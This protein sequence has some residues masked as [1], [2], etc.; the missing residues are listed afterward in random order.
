MFNQTKNHTQQ[1]GCGLFFRSYNVS[2]FAALCLF[3]SAVEYAIPKPLP[4]LRLGLANLPVLIAAKKFNVKEYA[5]LVILKILGQALLSGTLFS[6]V[7]VFSF[8]GSA[9]SA[10]IMYL[11]WILCKVNNSSGKNISNIGISLCGALGNNAAQIVCARLIMFGENTKYIAPLLLCSGFVTGFLLGIFSLFFEEKSVWLKEKVNENTDKNELVEKNCGNVE[12][13]DIC[14]KPCGNLYEK[15]GK[16]IIWFI[17]GFILMICFLF[18]QS[19]PII[20]GC[21][22]VFYI[23]A[24]IRRKG[25]VKLLPSLFITISVTIFALISP[26]GKVLFTVGKLRI[27]EGALLSGLHRSGIL[28]GM[29]FLSQIIV[30]KRVQLPGKAGTFVARIFE[31]LDALGEKRI[32]FAKGTVISSI[33]ARLCEIWEEKK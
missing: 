12:N 20:W 3:L 32:K 23:I 10:I 27:T 19:V 26:F 25:K 7:F 6:Y 13:L 29:V 4:F 18:I 5:V 2:F 28:V 30:N 21:V 17:T 16:E 22:V 24:L 8:A 15:S 11:V 31:I 33:D 9:A 1:N 14:G